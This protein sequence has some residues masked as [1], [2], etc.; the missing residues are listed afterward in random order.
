M[1]F[2]EIEAAIGSAGHGEVAI[3]NWIKGSAE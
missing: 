2:V 1:D 3:V